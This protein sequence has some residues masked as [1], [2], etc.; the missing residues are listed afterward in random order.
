MT[1]DYPELLQQGTTFKTF[2]VVYALAYN[3]KLTETGK[4][5]KPHHTWKAREEYLQDTN[6]P[7]FFGYFF[8]GDS[9]DHALLV[10]IDNEQIYNNKLTDI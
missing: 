4:E 2:N 1:L 6:V 9:V 10:S 7:P 8:I 3:G 5:G